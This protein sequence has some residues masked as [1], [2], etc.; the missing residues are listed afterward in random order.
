MALRPTF[1]ISALAALAAI[2]LALLAA[3]NASAAVVITVTEVGSSLRFEYSGGFTGLATRTATD[4]DPVAY[5]FARNFFRAL[6]NVGGDSPTRG[7][8]S[9]FQGAYVADIPSFSPSTGYVGNP[10]DFFPNAST[11]ITSVTTAEPGSGTMSFFQSSGRF[12]TTIGFT[13]G[14]YSTSGA[15]TIPSASFATLGLPQVSTRTWNWTQTGQSFVP[16]NTVTI[17]TVPEPETVVI[18]ATGGVAALAGGLI[19]RRRIAAKS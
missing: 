19:R 10:E 1:L 6:N 14:D 4:T 2:V 9:M 12:N 11:T 17:Q 15:F 5:G 3:S 8:D 18:L 13:S 7:G 16:G